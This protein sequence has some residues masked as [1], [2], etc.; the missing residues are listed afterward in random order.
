MIMYVGL[1][2]FFYGT[3]TRIIALKRTSLID[4]RYVVRGL[5]WFNGIAPIP[6]TRR[7]TIQ[8]LLHC[9]IFYKSILKRKKIHM[10]LKKQ[11]RT[12][13]KKKR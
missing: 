4:K 12:K 1:G 5:I 8:I 3:Y 7:T 10:F 9:Y 6:L 2:L 11:N 13:N